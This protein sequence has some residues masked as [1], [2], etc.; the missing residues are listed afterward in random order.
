MMEQKKMFSFA[1]A[2]LVACSVCPVSAYARDELYGKPDPTYLTTALVLDSD[3]SVEGDGYYWDADYHELTLSNFYLNVS[4]SEKGLYGISLPKDS[5]IILEDDNEIIVAGNYG[6]GIYCEGDLTFLGDGWLDITAKG[7]Y[8]KG[9]GTSNG[10]EIN[11][12]QQVDLKLDVSSYGLYVYGAK[13]INP[14]ISV[15]DEAFASIYIGN[16]D[17]AIYLIYTSKNPSDNWL[18]YTE[19]EKI[20]DDGESYIYLSAYQEE[21]EEPAEETPAAPFENPFLDIEDHWAKNA[22]LYAVE[23]GFMSGVTEKIFS[24]DTALSRASLVSILYTM[25]GKPEVTGNMTF[26]DVPADSDYADAVIWANQNKLISGYS[27][28]EFAPDKPITRE[29]FASILYRYEQMHGGGFSGTWAF[30]LDYPDASNVSSYAYEALCWMTMQNVFSGRD[31]GSLDPQGNVTRGETAK[32]LQN[33][34]SISQSKESET[35]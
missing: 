22:I 34:L 17:R 24:P 14:I 33:Y 25:E 3:T 35:K 29:Q 9:I 32:L 5:T 31:D 15:S 18:H 11:L 10:G 28:T 27:D 20:D 30:L 12:T 19:A 16:K 1:L 6:A 23:N 2:A 8:T 13:G 4:S 7:A 21:K 26:L